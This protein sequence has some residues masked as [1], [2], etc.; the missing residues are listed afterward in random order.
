MAGL[1][2]D[3][4]ADQAASAAITGFT[5]LGLAKGHACGGRRR[6]QVVVV[7]D[8]RDAGL[9]GCHGSDQAAALI[10]LAAHCHRW[11]ARSTTRREPQPALASA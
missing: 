4:V 5:K 10:G 7:S 3:F 6:Y 11:S 9:V 8:H 1:A 2:N